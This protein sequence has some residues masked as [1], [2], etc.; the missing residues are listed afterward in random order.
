MPTRNTVRKRLTTTRPW[1]WLSIRRPT[2]TNRFTSDM[3]ATTCSDGRLPKSWR[4][5]AIRLWRPI[6][7]TTVVFISASRCWH[8]WNM[9]TV[10][11][12]RQAERRATILSATIMWLST[13][14]IV[15]KWSSSPHNTPAKAWVRKRLRKKP[16]RR[17][18]SSRKL[19]RCWWNG[20]RTTPRCAPFGKRWTIGCM[21]VSTRP[22]RRLALVSTRYTM[23]RKPISRVRPR[24]R[25]VSPKVSLSAMRTTV[26]GQI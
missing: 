19:M 1:W 13:S 11:L 14:I 16:R 9:A 5:T 25:K 8:G 17:L 2:P 7:W 26:Y 22:T 15:S 10:R 6:S 3:C 23:S 18:R 24:W 12:L 21:L 20:S 4:P